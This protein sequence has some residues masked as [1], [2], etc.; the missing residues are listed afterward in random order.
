MDEFSTTGLGIWV[1]VC[2]PSGGGKDSV[3]AWTRERLAAHEGIVFARRMIT[4]PHQNGSDHEPVSATEFQRLTQAGAIA[5]HW[6]AHGFRYGISKRY[7]LHVA[8]GRV[9][10]VNGS[11]EHVQSLPRT[12][13][14]RCV[15][16]RA[17]QEKLIDRLRERGR[18][19]PDALAER[20]HRNEQL[21]HF[22]GDLEIVNDA[23]LA[24]AGAR[25]QG[26]LESL[27]AR[28]LHRGAHAPL[29]W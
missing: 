21:A 13:Q 7:A 5:W 23:D 25:L 2:G 15:A 8:Q 16:I 24:D 18:E 14:I 4:R 17:P 12:P 29:R 6:Q 9:V 26:W 22:K 20:R 1:F 27:A 19:A 10:V 3:I 28:G 11:R